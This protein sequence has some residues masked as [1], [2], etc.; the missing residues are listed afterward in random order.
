MVYYLPRQVGCAALFLLSTIHQYYHVKK[1]SGSVPLILQYVPIIFSDKAKFRNPPVP[2]GKTLADVF[3][4]FSS[5]ISWST[6]I[7]ELDPS[8]LVYNG[9][10]NP[11]FINWMLVAP[12]QNFVKPF[13]IISPSASDSVLS[14]GE[15]LLNI[16]YIL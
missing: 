5:P 7:S 6:K 13:R 3:E 15:Y 2:I 11:D 1:K 4:N 8:N 16:D 10:S 12:L 9:L 14:K